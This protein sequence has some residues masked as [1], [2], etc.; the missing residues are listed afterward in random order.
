M[1]GVD[2][3]EE[4]PGLE[5]GAQA[6]SKPSAAAVF[7]EVVEAELGA[8]AEVA[9]SEVLVRD[10]EEEGEEGALAERGE[11]GAVLLWD[12]GLRRRA[13]GARGEGVAQGLDGGGADGGA[14][15]E[16]GDGAGEDVVAGGVVVG[17]AR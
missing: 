3:L 7:V 8:D 4:V 11:D 17:V 14:E 1:S 2:E 10:R 5:E 12:Q 6:G 13:V 9:A 15:V 16:G